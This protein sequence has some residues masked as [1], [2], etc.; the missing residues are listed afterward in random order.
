MIQTATI[1]YSDSEKTF[2]GFIAWNDESH[3][4][5]PGIL[6]A[7]AFGG[8]SDFEREK[9]KE[10]AQLGYV[11]FAIDMYGKGKRAT[12]NDEA[13]KLMSELNNNRELLLKRIQLALTTLKSQDLID[14]QKIAAIGFCFG[15]KCVLD[16][17]RSGEGIKGVV[18]FHGVYDAP[19]INASQKINC[20]V[21]VLH[22][23]ED[24]ISQPDQTVALAQELTEKATDWQILSFGHTGHAF[25]N[26]KANHP[27]KGLFYHEQ[28]NKRAWKAM[29]LFFEEIF[30]H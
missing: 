6:I 4:D 27:E 26:P 3:D 20:S 1:N 8:L 16:L 10:L 28:S 30:Q 5:R 9:A 24:P 11:G 12:N 17:A 23:W 29:Q 25:T 2:E 7:H 21:L 13:R 15:G 18:S 22:G 14:E 19:Q